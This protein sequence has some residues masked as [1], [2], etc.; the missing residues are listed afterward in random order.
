[1][2]PQSLRSDSGST[3]PSYRDGRSSILL[4]GPMAMPRHIGSD[5]QNAYYQLDPGEDMSHALALHNATYGD[6][7]DAPWQNPYSA[8][9][10]QPAGS[11]SGFNEPGVGP[12]GDWPVAAPGPGATG[13][14]ADVAPEAYPQAWPNAARPNPQPGA[15]PTTPLYVGYAGAPP[16][17]FQAPQGVVTAQ[18]TPSL[19]IPPQVQAIMDQQAPPADSLPQ[20]EPSIGSVSNDQRYT[21]AA[22][23]QDQAD[24]AQRGYDNPGTPLA[25][26]YEG[27]NPYDPNYGTLG[28]EG[29]YAGGA[30]GGGGY[31]PKDDVQYEQ[32]GGSPMDYQPPPT[33]PAIVQPVGAQTMD[34]SGYPTWGL[35]QYQQDGIPEAYGTND[36][37]HPMLQPFDA[38][39]GIPGIAPGPVT[40]RPT[41]QGWGSED[42]PQQ[43]WQ[44]PMIANDMPSPGPMPTNDARSETWYQP[45]GMPDQTQMV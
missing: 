44:P 42:G 10:P 9:P 16:T 14:S 22:F 17:Q 23:A 4:E 7:V 31:G 41:M 45:Q 20:V 35:P 25:A 18:N 33:P 5:G 32:N 1:M 15:A 13:A 28:E 8:F 29:W 30:T 34:N 3:S 12:G 6:P 43:A 26:P 38:L 37:A 11:T 27:R 2:R 24:Y 19:A 36:Y 39:N 21:Q 40:G